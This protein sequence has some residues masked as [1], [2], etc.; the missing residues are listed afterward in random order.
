MS[1]SDLE[2][3]LLMCLNKIDNVEKINKDTQ[4]TQEVFMRHD[5]L[6]YEN[7][8]FF[9]VTHLYYISAMFTVIV[10]FSISLKMSWETLS[11]SHFFSS[12]LTS[13]FLLSIPVGIGCVLFTF[14]LTPL[15]LLLDTVLMAIQK[16]SGR[17]HA[18]EQVDYQ[19]SLEWGISA[20]ILIAVICYFLI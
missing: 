4:K 9:W 10:L 20:I 11:V 2:N 6:K 5:E 1:G 16:K 17:Y 18:K 19:F 8:T 14:A 12:L 3:N 13:V 15:M 7:F